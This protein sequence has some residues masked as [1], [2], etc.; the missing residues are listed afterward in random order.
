MF[1]FLKPLIAACALAAGVAHAAF[2]ERP[3]TIVVPYAPVAR[4]MPWPVWWPPAW[5][6]S[7]AA[8]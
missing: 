7:S 2:P 4:P 8:A 5:A 3:I 1:R 6:P